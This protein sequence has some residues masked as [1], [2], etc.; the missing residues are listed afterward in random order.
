MSGAGGFRWAP[1]PDPTK[2]RPNVDVL[3]TVL[4]T[5]LDKVTWP[6]VLV[7]LAIALAL[8][9]HRKLSELIERNIS[10]ETDPKKRRWRIDTDFKPA[11]PVTQYVQSQERTPPPS[12]EIFLSYA[13]SDRATAQAVAAALSAL[14][15]SVWWDRTIP[16]G[17][18]F[19][20]VIEAAL[21]TAKCVIVL[22]SKASVSS[23][24][25]KSEASEGARRRILIP[26]LIEDITIPLE[27]RRIQAASLVG[28][29]SSSTH[30]GF[31][32]LARS[33]TALLT[34]TRTWPRSGLA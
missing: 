16:P 23:D 26:A 20:Q 34:P 27:F 2:A 5:V 21:D 11:P 24:W 25:V 3:K 32:S 12:E 8:I 4:D 31:E 9:F 33:V 30:P 29:N 15:W 28:W 14:G 6:V 22:W 19:D 10:I 7:V 13:S 18:S 17:K 1:V